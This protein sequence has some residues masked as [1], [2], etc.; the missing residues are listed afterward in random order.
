MPTRLGSIL[1]LLFVCVVPAFAQQPPSQRETTCTFLDGKQITVRYPAIPY[2]KKSELPNGQPWPPESTPIYLFTQTN[3]AIGQTDIPAGAYS[4]YTIPG[5]GDSWTL[6]ISRDVT[7]DNKYD[8]SRD[9]GRVPMQTGTLPDTAKRLTAYFGRLA[10]KTCDLRLDYGT[11]R[12]YADFVE[13]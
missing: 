5:K 10:P 2:D 3:V 12:G 6:V 11:Q 13:K 7:Q 9:L 4:L 1:A 8:T